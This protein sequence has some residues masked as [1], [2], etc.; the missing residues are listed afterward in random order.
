MRQ[1]L[2]V[3]L[4]GRLVG[5]LVQ[6][7]HGGCT[8]QY[9]QAWVSDARSM[10]LSRSLPLRE[11]PFHWRECQGFFAGILP[12]QDKRVLVAR[13]TGVSANNDF[14]LLRKI[15]GECAG[16]V[17]F[18]PRGE[19][20]PP[21]S[22]ASRPLDPAELARLLRRLPGRPL[23][24]G[25][26]GVRLSL[27]GAQT[28]L[29][30]RIVDG[31][32]HLP[33]DSTPSTHIVKPAIDGLPGIVANEAF[34]LRLAAA[35]GIP[36]AR[37]TAE[38]VEDIDYLLVERYDRSPVQGGGPERLHQEDF[39]QALNV[40][41]S[42]KYQ[43]EGGPSLRQCFALLRDASTAPA[44]D[45]A[46]LLDSVAFNC[47]I[48]NNDAHG[49]NFSLLYSPDAGGG[50]SVRLAP[51][52]DLICTVR[53]GEMS[54]R[55][56]MRLGEAYDSS[57]LG[58]RDFDRFADEAE[59]RRAEVRRRVAELAAAAADKIDTVLAEVPGAGEVAEVVRRRSAHIA[60][61]LRG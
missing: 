24:A 21:A 20:S 50:V 53:Y 31:V 13:N 17:T 45:L 15:G 41:P 49:K 35:V 43:E 3:H 59:M 51:L 2:D 56:A 52:Y 47:V 58:A 44:R 26:A 40:A 46:T 57:R 33:L 55:M 61:M 12:E 5:Q 1:E 22:P 29:A 48:G 28:K 30:V 19:A 38:R 8:F 9:D 32:V 54:P 36:A 11:K 60:G 4:C 16:A 6:D 42:H 18:L 34:C 25:E 23:L 14:A 7:V 27:A 39:C 10:P 37:A